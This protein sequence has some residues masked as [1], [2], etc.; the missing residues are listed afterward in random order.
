MRVLRRR[1]HGWVTAWL[2]FQVVS[3]SALVPRDCC[4]AHA[5][6]AKAAEPCHDT[7][8]ASHCTMPVPDGTPCPM[9]REQASHH[10]H[11]RPP[12]DPVEDCSMRGICDGPEVAFMAL[13]SHAG[14]LTESVI[15]PVDLDARES[16]APIREHIASRLA[17]PDPPPPRA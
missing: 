16:V 3:V 6:A 2:V 4:D 9:H 11:G 17:S 14:V 8:A 12:A 1:L 5:H 13:L 10:E 15:V 7:V